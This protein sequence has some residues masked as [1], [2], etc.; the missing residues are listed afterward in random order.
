MARP[1][2][3]I[4]SPAGQPGILAETVL[5]A[6]PIPVLAIDAANRIR[7]ANPAAEPFFALAASALCDLFL[8]DVVPFASPVFGLIEQVRTAGNVVSEHEL[9]VGTPRTGPRLVNVTVSPLGE[10]PGAVVM[11]LRETSIAVKMDRQLLY[12]GAARSV[13]G[14]AAILAHEVKNPLS[15]IRGAAQL[16]EQSVGAEDRNLTRLIC[17]ETDRICA[18]VDGM[19][20]FSDKPI[21]RGPVNIH[22]VL[23]RVCRLAGA[24]FAAG[25]TLSQRYDPSLPPAYGNFDQLVQVFLN[26]VK[27]AAE[28]APQVGG[29]LAIGTAYRHGLRLSVPGRRRR[30]RL[31]LEVRVPDHGAGVA[32]ELRPH[33]FDPFITGKRQGSGLG[34]ALVAKIV[35]DHAGIVEFESRPRRTVFRVLL[36]IAEEAGA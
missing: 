24:G 11:V 19:E 4:W 1:S 34:L 7:Y 28:A 22:E 9:E 25:L 16:L 15:G 36:P 29:E 27:N 21:E 26:L 10:G 2:P 18:L 20:M 35:G 17:E 5:A 3:V 12:R 31:P 32:E 33:L 14:M 13:T 30:L 8:A 23:D 6:L